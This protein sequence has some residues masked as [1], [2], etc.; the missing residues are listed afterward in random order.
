M[1]LNEVGR[2]KILFLML[3]LPW[4]ALKAAK[5]EAIEAPL[6]EDIILLEKQVEAEKKESQNLENKAQTIGREIITIRQKMIGVAKK[7][8]DQEEVLSN[9]EIRLSS[10]EKEQQEMTTK[11]V[12]N[13]E[14]MIKVLSS[15]QNIALKP[16][17][18]IIVQPLEPIDIIRSIILMR[19][20]IPF[21]ELSADKI[22][23]D[24]NKLASLKA[25]IKSQY[26][27]ITVAKNSLD[28]EHQSIELLHQKRILLKKETEIEGKKA[29]GRAKELAEK[30]DDLRDLLKV[31]EEEKRKAEKAEQAEQEQALKSKPD[32]KTK[33]NVAIK[34]FDDKISFASARGRLPPPVRGKIITVYGETTRTGSHARGITIKTRSNAQVIAPFDGVV[35]FAGSFRG[36]GQLLIIQ[37]G[38]GY[39]TLLAGIERIDVSVNQNLL[40][41]EPVGLMSKDKD[42]NLY[43]EL[44]K[45]GQPVNPLPWLAKNN[46]TMG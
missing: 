19:D 42:P 12:K 4:L 29:A 7:I 3:V 43:L 15:L 11:L 30:A 38:G 2:L 26:A 33:E 5:V 27:R 23:E 34:S 21:I 36:Y 37:H 6:A 41:G 39:H 32:F 40:A 17:E 16:A 45:D 9:L 25:N 22:Q 13:N 46:N 31:L 1:I 44:R 28:N 20:S 8:Q 18:T 10:L 14:Q 35:L 24:L